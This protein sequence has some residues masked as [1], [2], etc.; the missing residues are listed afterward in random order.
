M[1][2]IICSTTD[3][4]FTNYNQ[5]LHSRHWDTIKTRFKHSPACKDSCHVC[6]LA[7][8]KSIT[9]HIHHRSYLNIGKELNQDLVELCA[10]CHKKVHHIAKSGCGKMTRYGKMTDI[11]FAVEYLKHQQTVERNQRTMKKKDIPKTIKLC[12]PWGD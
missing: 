2:T 5:Y 7:N 12:D 6:G 1:K 9:V 10:S 8:S 11:C 3:E 4:T